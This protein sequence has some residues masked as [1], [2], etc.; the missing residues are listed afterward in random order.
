MDTI[1]TV[2][3]KR[4]TVITRH[5]RGSWLVQLVR[6]GRVTRETTTKHATSLREAREI[7]SRF[8]RTGDK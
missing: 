5:G 4:Q 6:V 7:A 2:K 3:G 1:E 8:F